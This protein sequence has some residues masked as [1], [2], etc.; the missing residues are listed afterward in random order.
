MKM[1][2][3]QIKLLVLGH[4]RH[5]KDTF[6]ELLAEEF[7]YTFE[8]SSQAAADI[9]LYDELKDKYSYETP[10]EC[11]EDRMNHRLRMV[12]IYL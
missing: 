5:G 6:A 4:K 11:F 10:E 1:K 8:S 7:K 9:F 12:L 2:I 3:K